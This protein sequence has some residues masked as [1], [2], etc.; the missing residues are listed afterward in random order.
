MERSPIGFHHHGYR[1]GYS[2]FHKS[3]SV[4]ST[5]HYSDMQIRKNK[6][7][8]CTYFFFQVIYVYAMGRDSSVGIATRY[9]L[10]GPGIEY[11]WRRDFPYRS[12]PTPG[13]HPASY[14][15]GTGLLP[16]I[17]RPGRG[18]DHPPPS[19]AEVKER[20]EL[21]SPFGPSCVLG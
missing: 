2:V 17:K 6:K 12:I 11:R 19:I 8:T 18:V 5:R 15:R 13:T 20:I 16:K 9:G 21:Y 7:R 1:D 4:R 14:T 3:Q 10:D